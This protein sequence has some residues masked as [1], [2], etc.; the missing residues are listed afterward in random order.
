MRTRNHVYD[1]ISM[2]CLS[3]TFSD[4][5]L[6]ADFSNRLD[7]DVRLAIADDIWGGEEYNNERDDLLGFFFQYYIEET[8]SPCARRAKRYHANPVVTRPIKTHIELL[9]FVR[10]LKAYGDRTRKDIKQLAD[11]GSAEGI[12]IDVDAALDLTVKI[13]FM[14]SCRSSVNMITTG[15]IFRPI[16]KESESLEA[17]FERVLPRHEIEPVEKIETIKAR[18]LRASY[19]KEYATIN[20]EWTNNLPDHLFLQITDDWKSLRVF[21]HAGFLEMESRTLAGYDKS[22]STSESLSR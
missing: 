6:D 17:F 7:R 22:I 15:H 14:I 1:I 13:L 4:D 16:W 21:G 8:T 20:I 12:C 9:Q 10:A 3:N 2:A 5:T 19:I 11:I 18:K